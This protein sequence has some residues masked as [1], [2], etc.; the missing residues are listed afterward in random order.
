MSWFIVHI[1]NFVGF[2]KI[3]NLNIFRPKIIYI[4]T[5]FTLKL[6]SLK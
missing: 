5:E 2:K 1:P 4:L 3:I 6:F